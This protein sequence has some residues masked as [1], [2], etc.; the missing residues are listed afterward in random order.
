MYEA[1]RWVVA[2]VRR[3]TQPRRGLPKPCAP[4]PQKQNRQQGDMYEA[5]RWVVA[6]V[7]HPNTRDQRA[8]AHQILRGLKRAEWVGACAW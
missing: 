3:P 4:P 1:L 5:L 2:T 7:R 6:T 8:L